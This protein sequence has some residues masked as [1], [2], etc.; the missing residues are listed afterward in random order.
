MKSLIRS[1]RPGESVRGP[2]GLM[3]VRTVLIAQHGHT[4]FDSQN[5]FEVKMKSVAAGQSQRLG[6]NHLRIGFYFHQLVPE[7]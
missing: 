6:Q 3:V 4:A 5:V 1:R 2:V 7:H